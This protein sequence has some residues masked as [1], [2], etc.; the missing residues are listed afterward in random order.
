MKLIKLENTNKSVLRD[1]KEQI[2]GVGI[3]IR[4]YYERKMNTI[5]TL[6][7][8]QCICCINQNAKK[9]KCSKCEYCVYYDFLK[10]I[11]KE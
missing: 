7:H 8:R 10:E 2:V 3:E 9:N 5:R 1:I 4:Q 11:N 6:I